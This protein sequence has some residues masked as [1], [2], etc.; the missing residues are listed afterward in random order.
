M[1]F[2]RS[3]AFLKSAAQDFKTTGAIAPSS[4]AL[5]LAMTRELDRPRHGSVRVLEVGGGTG[6]ITRII[7][8]YIR[9]GDRLDVYEI[10]P[11]FAAIICNRSEKDPEFFRAKNAIYVHNLPIQ[12][13]DPS[14]RYDFIIS[15]LPFTNFDAGMVRNIFEIYRTVL[16]P[17]GVCSF[18]EYALLRRARRLITGTPLDRARMTAVS[19][20]ISE[21]VNRYC[22]KRDLVVLNLPPAIVRYIRF[23]GQRAD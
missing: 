3:R 5:G 10:N 13:I 11:E 14:A 15:C 17:G 18:F 19:K 1:T 2:E 20:I 12:Q 4:T 22:Y 6:S 8:R 7:A 21:Y 23:A 9:P 16:A